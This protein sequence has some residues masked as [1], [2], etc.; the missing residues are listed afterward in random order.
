M[1]VLNWRRYKLCIATEVFSMLTVNPVDVILWTIRRNEKDVIKLYDSLSSIMQL[2]TGTT[3][4][5]FGYW[6][7]DVHDPV[8]AQSKLCSL[9]GNLADINT[10]NTII[11]VGSGYGTPALQWSEEFKPRNIICLN[12]NP[13]QLV[14]GFKRRNQL[15]HQQ[16]HISY[17]N[18]TSLS[19]PFADRTVERIIAL[20]S[21]QHFK[22]FDRFIAESYRILQPN[23]VL[24]ISMPVTVF[25]ANTM[26]KLF[27][28]GI[29]NLTWSSER[30]ESEYVKST[31]ELHKFRILDISMI[32][33]QVYAPLALYYI[34]HRKSLRE[35]IVTSY[36][37]IIERILYNSLVKMMNISKEG[38]IE[39]IV[40]KAQK[41]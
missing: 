4:L 28:L 17:I 9:V 32:G 38:L 6:E 30:Y 18:S 20:E 3:M 14:K 15:T 27:K 19:L 13:Q 39:Y 41:S 26:K 22:P 29:L 11:D 40:I 36:P 34:Q 10:S 33:A 5:N 21:A 2:A 31:I 24:I 35:K 25:L 7:G 23:G 16:T 12:I 37:P 1:Q 8:Q